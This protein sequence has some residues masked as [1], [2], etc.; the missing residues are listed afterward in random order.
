MHPS[1]ESYEYL[2]TRFLL[3]VEE[4]DLPKPKCIEII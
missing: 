2:L 1:E 4:L 3:K